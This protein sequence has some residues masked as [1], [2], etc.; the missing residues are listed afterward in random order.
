MSGEHGSYTQRPHTERYTHTH[1]TAKIQYVCN[2]GKNVTSHIYCC[3]LLG[4]SVKFFF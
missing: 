2:Q 3:C 4:M 1:V